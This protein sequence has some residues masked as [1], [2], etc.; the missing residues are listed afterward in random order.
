M[1]CTRLQN[2]WNEFDPDEQKNCD[3]LL[4]VFRRGESRDSSANRAT[5]SQ[6]V[7]IARWANVKIIGRGRKQTDGVWRYL[8]R[9]AFCFRANQI[10]ETFPDT[11]L[12]TKIAS[13]QSITKRITMHGLPLRGWLA[14]ELRAQQEG[15]IQ[16]RIVMGEINFGVIKRY[17]FSNMNTVTC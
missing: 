5:C 12:D 16:V 14:D 8:T 1:I 3:F 9:G 10:T 6:F 4:R 17:I 2:S 13:G 15:S 7:F 11:R